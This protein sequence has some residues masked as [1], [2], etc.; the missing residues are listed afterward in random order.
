MDTIMSNQK[1]PLEN[2]PGRQSVPPPE[3][4]KINGISKMHPASTKQDITLAFRALEGFVVIV[5]L[6]LCMGIWYFCNGTR[7]KNRMNP[8]ISSKGSSGY[9]FW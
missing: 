9:S 5:I 7:L 8:S 2:R 1:S 3:L 4:L 6:L